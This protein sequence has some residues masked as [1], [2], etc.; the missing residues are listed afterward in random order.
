ML[1]LHHVHELFSLFLGHLVHLLLNRNG[2]VRV[3]AL[4][5]VGDVILAR[6]VLHLESAHALH[7]I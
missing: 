4:E 1:F 5:E 6:V 2:L 7:H 3:H